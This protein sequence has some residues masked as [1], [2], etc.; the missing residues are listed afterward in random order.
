[1]KKRWFKNL[2]LLALILV[3]NCSTDSEI[4]ENQDGFS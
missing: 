1:M 4:S 2:R 3:F